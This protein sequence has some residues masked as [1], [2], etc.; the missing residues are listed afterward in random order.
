MGTSRGASVVHPTVD[1][2]C[3]QIVLPGKNA[4]WYYSGMAVKKVTNYGMEFTSDTANLVKKKK[5]MVGAVRD[6]SGQFITVVL[7]DKHI[8]QPSICV[9][10][11][12]YIQLS[13]LLREASFCS[14]CQ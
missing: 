1:F 7:L 14:Q 6:P 8:K 13:T 5:N 12:R 10:S 9:Y 3:Y 4:H 2:E 11:L